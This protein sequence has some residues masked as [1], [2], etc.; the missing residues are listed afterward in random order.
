MGLNI[1]MI[2][3]IGREIRNDLNY[4]DIFITHLTKHI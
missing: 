2:H 3:L 4:I 1:N